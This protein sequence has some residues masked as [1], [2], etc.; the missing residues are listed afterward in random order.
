MRQGK[1]IQQRR[2]AR[3]EKRGVRSSQEE[4]GVAEV[5][6]DGPAR[7]S[8]STSWSSPPWLPPRRSAGRCSSRA[9][10]KPAERLT[11]TS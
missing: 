11:H 4:Y 7:H 6:K 10:P 2:S 5:G 9:W 3:C 1:R 8:A